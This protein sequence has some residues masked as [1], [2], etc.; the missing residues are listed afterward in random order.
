MLFK[1]SDNVLFKNQESEVEE[2]YYNIACS[3]YIVGKNLNI[4]LVISVGQYLN[5]NI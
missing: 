4:G 2:I 5:F 3:I 1:S